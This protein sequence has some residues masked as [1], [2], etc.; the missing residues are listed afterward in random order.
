MLLGQYKKDWEGKTR[1][2][3]IGLGQ[4]PTLK[5]PLPAGLEELACS[6]NNAQCAL[7]GVGE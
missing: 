7:A 3:G 4:A 5:Q 6:G 1:V 2:G